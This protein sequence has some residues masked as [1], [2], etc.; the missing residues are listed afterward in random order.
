MTHQR[1]LLL[2]VALALLPG[3]VTA[4]SGVY[5]GLGGGGASY[6]L[7]HRELSATG[8]SAPGDQAGSLSVEETSGV[9]RILIG[10]RPHQRFAVEATW[11]SSDEATITQTAVDLSTGDRSTLSN[12]IDS[13]EG[14]A[15]WARGILPLGKGKVTRRFDLF[16][17]LGVLF[18]QTESSVSIVLDNVFDAFGGPFDPAAQVLPGA[19]TAFRDQASTSGNSFG[20][21][22]GM[23]F[24]IARRV[25]L[26]LEWDRFLDV[27]A[28]STSERAAPAD[29]V[30]LDP[31]AIGFEEDLDTAAATLVF[32]F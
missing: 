4:E 30:F 8:P 3:F 11:Q 12:S 13:T 22:L 7:Q 18:W 29:S 9:G 17:K 2:T 20:F 21:G 1:V 5:V 28:V 26:R 25:G 32:R 31:S 23:D 6:H 10:Y 16:A 27:G 19:T 24:R 14:L 15:L